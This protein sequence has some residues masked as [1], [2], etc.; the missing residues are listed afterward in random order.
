MICPDGTLPKK[1]QAMLQCLGLLLMPSDMPVKVKHTTYCHK[2][3]EPCLVKG[4]TDEWQLERYDAQ[5]WTLEERSLRS[6]G[7]AVPVCV[8]RCV[9][10]QVFHVCELLVIVF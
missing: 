5:D 9:C 2:E 7:V 6:S 4:E 3:N 8:R 10:C 1:C